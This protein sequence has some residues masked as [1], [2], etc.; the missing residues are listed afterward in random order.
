[1]SLMKRTSKLACSTYFI[2]HLRPLILNP[3]LEAL[4]LEPPEEEGSSYLA[5]LNKV[6]D[7]ID[8]PPLEVGEVSKQASVR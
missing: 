1:M 6:P 7:F 2:H 8:E 5:D 3:E 4:A